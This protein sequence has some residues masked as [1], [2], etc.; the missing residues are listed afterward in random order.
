MLSQTFA[1]NNKIDKN[2]LF[3]TK[4]MHKLPFYGIYAKAYKIE[5]FKNHVT[6][7]LRVFLYNL[8]SFVDI[9]LLNTHCSI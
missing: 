8:K 1:K 7:W 5:I 6:H 2:S 4:K 9:L 3:L